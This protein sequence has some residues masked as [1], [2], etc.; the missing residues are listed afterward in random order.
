MDEGEAGALAPRF[1]VSPSLLTPTTRKQ[2]FPSRFNYGSTSHLGFT[3]RP[4]PALHVILEVGGFFSR[5]TSHP[6]TSIFL[7]LTLLEPTRLRIDQP[8]LLQNLME[9]P[10]GVDVAMDGVSLE[11]HGG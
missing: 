4:L 3:L 7:P 10:V 5:S 11:T 8:V 2:G 1:V 9:R 6:C